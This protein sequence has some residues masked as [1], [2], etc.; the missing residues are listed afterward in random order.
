MIGRN[1]RY[2]RK[3]RGMTLAQLSE[4]VGISTSGL[5]FFET[6]DREPRIDTARRIAKELDVSLY[7]LIEEDTC[8]VEV[9]LDT[10][11]SLIETLQTLSK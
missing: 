2:Y 3:L 6:S 1:I 9:P 10:V 11:K 5:G 4:K 7:T 8:V